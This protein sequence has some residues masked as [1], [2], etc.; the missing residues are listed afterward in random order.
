MSTAHEVMLIA[1]TEQR[2]R[3]SFEAFE[4]LDAW[5]RELIA[6]SIEQHL[7]RIKKEIEGGDDGQ[8]SNGVAWPME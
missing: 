8:D 1:R 6:Q 3:K 2:Q 4:A 5:I 7:A